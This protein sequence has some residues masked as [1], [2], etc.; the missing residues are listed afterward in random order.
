[1]INHLDIKI[2]GQV[3]GVFFR[4]SAKDK[5]DE[6]VVTGFARNEPD[7]TVYIEA[8]G[9]KEGLDKF[10]EWCQQGPGAA[11]VRKV[12]FTY[13]SEIKNFKNFSVE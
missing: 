3:Q 2:Y 4:Y 10:L 7:G 13:G 11:T 9:E 8:E 12:D 5:A 1:M 6:L